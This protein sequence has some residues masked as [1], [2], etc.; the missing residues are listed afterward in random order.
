MLGSWGLV[1]RSTSVWAA[2]LILLCQ[3][4]PLAVALRTAPGS[5]CANVCNKQSTNT[6]GSEITCLDTD[7]TSTSKGSQFKQCVDC[8]LRS[9]YSDPSSGETDVDWGLYNLR[10]T[11]TS[12]VYGFPK[13]VSNISTQCTVNCQP[14]DRALEFDL[15]DPGAN[16]FYTW[17]GTTTF[18]DN[19]ITQ[20]EQCYN[21]TL[22]QTQDPTN[23]QS[24]VFMANFLEALRY[25]CHF[26][27]PTGFAFPIS[28]TRIF[29]ESLLPSSTVDLINPTSTGGPGVNLA[30]VIALPVLGFVILLCALS[31][32][33]F[34]F[35][36][37]RRRKARKHRQSSH[38]HARWNDTGIS[39]PWANYHEMYSPT[40]YQQGHGQHQQQQ[41]FSFVDNDGQ[42]RDVGYSKNLTEV[43]A[44]AVATP[45]LNLSPDGEKQKNP[46]YPEYFGQDS[47][48]K[49]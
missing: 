3:L 12:C 38:L 45:P 19:L 33:C 43:T 27:T 32:C 14:L 49:R 6:T 29:S 25:N 7:F 9:T 30:L 34:F 8:Q 26:R 4:V 1:P 42:Y 41:G 28:P 46:E 18:A 36:R 10:Y 5:P 48:Q 17:C 24:Q 44:S 35:I 11:F 21:F 40:M 39:T 15:T 16:N 47:K 23:G 13:S 22:T 31:I 2:V 37:W 20:C